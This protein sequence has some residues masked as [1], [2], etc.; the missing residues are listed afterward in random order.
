MVQKITQARYK[1]KSYTSEMLPEN[2]LVLSKTAVFL[3]NQTQSK[4]RL[5]SFSEAN[6]ILAQLLAFVYK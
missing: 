5:F 3:L 4:D 6:S 1:F 2:T